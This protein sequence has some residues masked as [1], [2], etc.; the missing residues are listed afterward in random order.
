M[1]TVSTMVSTVVITLDD[2][3]T[4]TSA[5]QAIEAS[6][7]QKLELFDNSVLLANL[8]QWAGSGFQNSYLVYQLSIVTPQKN[9]N[10]YL[11]SDGTSKTVWDYIPFCLGYP[12]TTL[13]AT[14]QARVSGMT[15]SF[16]VEEASTIVLKL[17]V[18]K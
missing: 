7:K 1:S 6:N 15:F 10:M 14:F 8:H 4:S 13:V 11:C 5:L 17:H 9:A 12:I 2:L 18:S 3:I 16:S